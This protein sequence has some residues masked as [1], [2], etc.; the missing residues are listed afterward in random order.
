MSKLYKKW[1]VV[2][3]DLNPTKGSEITKVRPCLIVS[4]NAANAALSTL[5]IVPFTSTNKTYPTR[6]FTNDKGKPR[7]LAFDQIKTIDKSRVIKKD[8]EL[9]RKLREAANSTLQIMFSEK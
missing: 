4:P 3:V 8:G 9:D 1:N 6:L 7:A 2:L 5:I